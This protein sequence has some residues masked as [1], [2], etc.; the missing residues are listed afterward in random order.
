[1]TGGL[2][3]IRAAG[4]VFGGLLLAGPALAVLIAS[5]DGT[6]NTTAPA[7]DPGFANLGV[8]SGLSAIYL[9]AGWVLTANHVPTGP[10]VLGGTSYAPVA[11]SAVRLEDSPGVPTDLKLFRLVSDPGLPALDISSSS[12]LHNESVVMVGHGHNRGAATSWNGID[13][14]SWAGASAMRWGTNR[15]AARN[16]TIVISSSTVHAFSLVFDD[17]GGVSD[18]A[19]AVTG[20]SGGAVF[21]DAGSAW[22]LGGVMFAAYSFVGQPAATSLFGNGTYAADLSYYR[23]QILAITAEPACSNGVDDDGDGLVDWPDDPGCTDPSDGFETNALVACDDGFDDDGDGLV[24]WPADPGCKSATSLAED[25]QCDDGIDNDG[26]GGVDWD[27]GPGGGS[28]DPQCV[29]APWRNA[30]KSG[31]C[32]LGFELVLVVPL[33]ARL[34]RRQ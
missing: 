11:G 1:M 12:P 27:G 14:W 8:A 33:L 26:D 22:E 30:E 28:P 3:W 6:G 29:S 34:R 9:G 15:V 20:D 5:G 4:A 23:S 24:D 19:T 16:L 31:S 18:E 32:G 13:G 25:P 21:R 2:R 10:V 7:D 17:D